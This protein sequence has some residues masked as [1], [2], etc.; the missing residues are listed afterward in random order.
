M[1]FFLC[2]IGPEKQTKIY[3]NLKSQITYLQSQ[4]EKNKP[5]FFSI[6]SVLYLFEISRQFKQIQPQLVKIITIVSQFS[7]NVIGT[8]A[9]GYCLDTLQSFSLS[10]TLYQKIYHKIRAENFFYIL[11]SGGWSCLNCLVISNKYRTDDIEKT[12]A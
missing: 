11:T 4:F 1:Y 12:E 9:V 8:D 10:H 5:P 6:S 3:P 7:F 2:L